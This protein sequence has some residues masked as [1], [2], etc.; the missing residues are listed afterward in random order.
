MELRQAVIA[1]AAAVMAIYNREV[2]ESTVTFDLI[3]RTLQEQQE[4]IASRSGGLAMLVVETHDGSRSVIAGFASISFY[5]DRPGYRT[6]VEDSVYVHRDYHGRGIGDLL[7]G[8]LVDRE[9]GRA[10]V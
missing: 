1:D 10:H 2:L 7:L 8:G 3:P 4:Y 6:S 5:R 9:I